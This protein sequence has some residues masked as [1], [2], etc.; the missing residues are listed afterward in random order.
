MSMVRDFSDRLMMA[1]VSAALPCSVL[2]K[3]KKTLD[4]I[5][6]KVTKICYQ[7]YQYVCCRGSKNA[8]QSFNN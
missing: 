6:Y 3:Q 2:D 8:L 4:E 1:N 7:I 5:Y